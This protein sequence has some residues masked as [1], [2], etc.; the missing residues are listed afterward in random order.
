MSGRSGAV[1]SPHAAAT[2]VMLHTRRNLRRL[3]LT[4]DSNGR[5][6]LLGRSAAELSRAVTPPA[7]NDAGRRQST[8]VIPTCADGDERQPATHRNGGWEP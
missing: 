3:R 2:K 8:G 1:A 6:A 7:V 4:G 5:I